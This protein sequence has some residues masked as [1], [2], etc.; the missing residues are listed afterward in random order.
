[1]DNDGNSK[2][3]SSFQLKGLTFLL[4]C[5]ERARKLYFYGVMDF[6]GPIFMV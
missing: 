5:L 1:M 2:V 4:S 3:I 6:Y